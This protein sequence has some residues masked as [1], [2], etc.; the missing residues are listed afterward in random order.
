MGAEIYTLCLYTKTCLSCLF[1]SIRLVKAVGKETCLK[2]N[3]A[4]AINSVLV[5]KNG[6]TGTTISPS[7]LRINSSEILSTSNISESL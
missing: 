2:K 6:S 4:T 7:A 1:C 5:Y 3:A